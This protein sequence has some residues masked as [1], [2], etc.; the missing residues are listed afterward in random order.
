MLENIREGAQKPWVKVVIF[1]VIISFIFAG[2]FS[3][4]S[5]LGDRNAIATVDGESI[6]F[7]QFKAAYDNVKA[8]N[9]QLYQARLKSE[10]GERRFQE[11][12]L[13]QLITRKIIESSSGDLGLNLSDDALR[14]II[15]SEANYQVD[16]KYSAELARKTIA[17]AGLTEEGFKNWYKN[18]EVQQQLF[19]GLLATEFS[20]PNEIEKDYQLIAQK[21]SGR[22]LKVNYKPFE[23]AAQFSDDEIN[24][25]Y[26]DNQEEYRIE[27]KVSVDYIELSIANL[28]QLQSPTDEQVKKYYEENIQRFQLDAERQYSHILINGADETGLNKAN[29]ISERIKQGEDFAEIAKSES[30]DI[31]TRETG[32][33]LG[34][35]VPGALD[36]ESEQAA[37]ALTKIG[38]VTTP[39]KLK[40]GYQ[41]LQL[42]SLKEGKVQPLEDVKAEIV[43]ELSQQLAEES[44]FAKLEILKEKTLVFSDS[45]SEAAEALG[46][47]VQTSPLFSQTL[48]QGLFDNQKVKEVSFSTEVLNEKLNSAI[49][50]ISDNHAMVLRLKEH[51]PSD[52]EPLEKVLEQV[53]KRVRHTKG[54][55]AAHDFA[56]NLLKQLESADASVID[57]LIKPYEF[58]W[59][60]LDKVERN[61]ASLSYLENTRFFKIPEPAANEANLDLVEDF[62]SYTVLELES[63]EKGDLK[64]ADD[65]RKKQRELYISSFFSNSGYASYVE[66]LRKKADVERKSTDLIQ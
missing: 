50:E 8:Q 61:N 47:K 64:A 41:L 11:D 38:D 59:I 56:N 9:P 37:E 34:V 20:L 42:T 6:G 55:Q 18:R 66:S 15:Q 24:Q 60:A 10:D 22:A 57:E 62:Q 17:Q 3:A 52:I 53:R 7:H 28:Q 49:V 4:S 40:I 51:K 36:P 33:D 1:A 30:D 45:L 27:E 14:K 46:L 19:S 26:Q 32:G 63:V 16:G 13:Q 5:L 54:K 43:A 2:G 44:Y 58:K 23:K 35:M 65:A 12:I 29:S 31:P 25:Y 48:G 21:R 39:V